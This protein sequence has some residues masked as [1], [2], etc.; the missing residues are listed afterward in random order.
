MTELRFIAKPLIADKLKNMSIILSRYSRG[1]TIIELLITV[2]IISILAAIIIVAYGGIQ[3]RS[4]DT[5]RAN[6]IANIKKALLAYDTVNGGVVR[7][8]VPGY[9]KPSDEPIFAG[10]DVSTSASWLLFLRSSRGNMPVDPIN[11]TPNT[12]SITNTA[13]RIYYYYCYPA[14]NANA[15]PDSAAVRLGYHLDSGANILDVFPVSACLTSIP[16]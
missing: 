12:A 10:W 11:Q 13:N 8:N 5:R 4:R 16:S 2:V 1:F 9:S 15:Y 6:D 14:G 3:E 7:P